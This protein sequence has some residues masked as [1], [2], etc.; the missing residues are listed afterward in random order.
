MLRLASDPDDTYA[1]YAETNKQLTDDSRAYRENINVLGVKNICPFNCISGTHQGITYTVN[2][3]TYVISA[4]GT[5]T[6]TTDSV[7]NI[8]T[9]TFQPGTYTF[10]AAPAGASSTTYFFQLYNSSQSVDIHVYD[11]DKDVTFTSTKTAT[12]RMVVKKNSAAIS[13]LQFKPMIR[14]ASDTDATYVPYA[15]TNQQAA[16][17]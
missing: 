6:T 10:S 3:D 2:W 7:W 4:T 15:M 9:I 14:L 5:P 12:Y 11:V 17:L 16:I 13:N 8:G 1:P